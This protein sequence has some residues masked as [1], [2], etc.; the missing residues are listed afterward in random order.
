MRFILILL[1]LFGLLSG[2]ETR[3]ADSNKIK[4]LTNLHDLAKQAREAN[5]P[6]MLAVGAE[7]CGFC[8][9]LKEEVLDP[10]AL[11][12]LY[13]GKYMYFRYIS[14]DDHDTIAG[15]NNQPITKEDLSNRF[16]ADLTPT[17]IFI[18]GYG[19]QVAPNIVGIVDVYT[20]TILMHKNLNIAYDN[21]Q[22]PLRI[23]SIAEDLVKNKE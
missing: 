9:V 2:C 5:L 23:P 19:K 22:N 1:L 13:E 17:I 11:G 8:D 18:D 10:M 20:Y 15:I 3:A 7:W 6:I 14:I 4:E 16:D 12:E 21:M